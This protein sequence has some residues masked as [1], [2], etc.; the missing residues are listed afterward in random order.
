[1]L[2]RIVTRIRRMK[3]SITEIIHG[4]GDA[5]VL[6]FAPLDYERLIE[7]YE[8]GPFEGR[9]LAAGARL[10]EKMI[11]EEDTI[12]L[13]VAGALVVGGFGGYIIDLMEKGLVDVICSTGAQVYHDLHFAYGLP[14][15]LGSPHVDD[16]QLRKEGVV[17]IYDLFVCEKETLVKQDEI[18]QEFGRKCRLKG[19]FSS[20]DLNY[21]L[22]RYVLQTAPYP[23][24]SF[25][26]QAAKL[27]VPIFLDSLANHSLGMNSAKLY[28][29]GKS[30]DPS[31]SLDVLESAAL[32]YAAG[33]NGFFLLGGGG[34]KNFIQQGG[35]T[36]SQILGIKHEGAERGIQ[37]TTATEKDGGLS[38]C[39]FHEAVTWGKYG[40]AG[41]DLVQIWGEASIIAPLV[42]GYAWN[43]SRRPLKK[44]M[45]KKKEVYKDLVRRVKT[46]QKNA[47]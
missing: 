16:N 25:V 7:N 8:K 19:N 32:Q 10:Y 3:K 45:E 43:R 30:F 35:P 40:K 2:K 12:W 1:M 44:L 15:F 31:P 41:P 18:I 24:K 9:N 5:H 47:P 23:D 13:G 20:A 26:A 14:V 22:G 38:G 4:C 21:A 29:K 36:L 6:R 39:T 27:K 17:R 42:W 37:I 28:L 33:N 11:S 34:P 46:N